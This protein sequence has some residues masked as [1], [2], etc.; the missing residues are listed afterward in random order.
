MIDFS[1]VKE[2][3]IPEGVVASMSCAGRVLWQ[4]QSKVYK[5]ELAYLEGTG[6]QW[7]NTGIHPTDSSIKSEVKIAY[8]STSTGQLMGAG[9]AGTERF[10]FG[11]ESG[12]FRF[13]FG[14]SWFDANSEVKTP[15]TEPHIWVLDAEAQ[16]GYIDGVE[17]KTTN[18]YLP[19]GS[20]AFVLFARGSSTNSA[21]NGNRTKGKLYYAKLWNAGTLVRDLIPVLD[22]NDRP[23]MYDKVSGELFYNQ[24][25][26]EFLYGETE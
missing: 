15:D 14:R 26:D 11:V 16:A 3:V 2:L 24:G 10:N 19:G 21:E 1:A 4:K 23:C 25:A 5:T 22:W 20:R 9:T 17:Q 8:S 12:R 6:T 13:G 18:T 7:I